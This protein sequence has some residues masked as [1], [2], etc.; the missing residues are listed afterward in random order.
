V[1]SGGPLRNFIGDT[2][3]P[4]TD[5]TLRGALKPWL[6]GQLAA[7][8]LAA[9]G[10]TASFTLTAALVAEQQE[11]PIDGSVAVTATRR[12]KTTDPAE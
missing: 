10:D 12:G 3:R 1:L 11:I 9:E 2:S 5:K 6:D 7:G 4:A 8:G